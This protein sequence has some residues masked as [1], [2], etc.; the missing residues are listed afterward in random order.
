MQHGICVLSVVP[1]RSEPADTSEIVSQ[2][3]FGELFQIA[4][5]R[6][7]WSKII[8]AYD[9][10]E[11]WVDKKQCCLLTEDDFQKLHNNTKTV[12]TDTLAIIS[13]KTLGLSYPVVIG[14]SLP[15]L[16]EKKL[17]IAGHEY[18]FDGNYA[19][20]S[21]MPDAGLITG[22]ALKFLNAPYLWGGRSPF[23]IDCS[24]FTQVVM[25]LCGIALLR[26]AAQQALQGSAVDFV[27]E[28]LPGDLAFFENAENRF[29]HTGIILSGQKII[30]ASGRVRIDDIDHE[31]IFNKYLGAYSHKL[32]CIRRFF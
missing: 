9:N 22:Y 16:N 11:G 32:R 10:Y 29:I 14:S 5:T 17:P 8:M 7:S 28:A 15:G 26:D 3:L 6:N 30:H 12:V 13:D 20:F 23:G 25:K 27:E 31:G 2:L 24:G 19:E 4:E 21:V 1:V 18:F